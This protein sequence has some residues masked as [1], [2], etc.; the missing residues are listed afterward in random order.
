MQVDTKFK[1]KY[2]LIYCANKMVAETKVKSQ[3]KFPTMHSLSAK[4]HDNSND[5]CQTLT[6]PFKL[7]D[8][9]S[10]FGGSFDGGWKTFQGSSIPENTVKIQREMGEKL[11]AQF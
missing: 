10:N 8:T 11:G 1:L 7:E 5:Y 3:T 2:L 4:T 6:L 9:G